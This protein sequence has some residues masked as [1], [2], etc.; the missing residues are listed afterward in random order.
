M[1]KTKPVF[2]CADNIK[3]TVNSDNNVK[4]RLTGITG[5]D[6]SD[7]DYLIAGTGA[8]GTYHSSCSN[9]NCTLQAVT[10]KSK[11]KN[12]TAIYMVTLKN[13]VGQ[14]TKYCSVSFV[15]GATCNCA[16]YC[17]AGCESNVTTGNVSNGSF[18]GCVFFT[19]ATRI[20]VNKGD[21]WTING[22][23]EDIKPSEE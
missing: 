9:S 2:S 15:E 12:D 1:T 3:A 20:N 22:W 10:N 17:G 5:C 21:A 13:S 16:Q 11:S 6:D 4:I 23:H 18:T 14:E 8:D 7:C 19:S